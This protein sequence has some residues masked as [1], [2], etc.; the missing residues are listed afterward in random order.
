MGNQHADTDVS[1]LVVDL[2]IPGVPDDAVQQDENQRS[3]E[4][5]NL[6]EILERKAENRQSWRKKKPEEGYLK[7]IL[8][9]GIENR[10]N[11]NSLHKRVMSN[12][13]VKRR[14]YSKRVN[15]LIKLK[16]KGLICVEN[17]K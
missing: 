1:N 2:R 17:R 3:V 8:K 16:E 15:G 7:L 14:N 6:R 13:N 10:E 9:A 5:S 12:L 4:R 11:P